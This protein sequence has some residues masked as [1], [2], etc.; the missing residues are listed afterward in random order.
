M[1]VLLPPDAILLCMHNARKEA[2]KMVP[3]S[4]IFSLS[5]SEKNPSDWE[6]LPFILGI[7]F[8]LI[9]AWEEDQAEILEKKSEGRSWQNSNK[10]RR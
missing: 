10:H 6:W 4:W 8:I 7:S 5:L 2:K 9:K 1:D 3:E